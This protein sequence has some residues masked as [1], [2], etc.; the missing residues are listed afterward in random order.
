MTLLEL[1]LVD[2]VPPPSAAAVGSK[3]HVPCPPNITPEWAKTL[4]PDLKGCWLVH[5][6]VRHMRWQS[7][8][9]RK[10][11]P[12]TAS[13]AYGDESEI[14]EWDSLKHALQ[15]VWDCHFDETGIVCPYIFD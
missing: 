5:D 14:S 12:R 4:K 15:F 8:Y 1:L 11:V 6:S 3:A 9:P 7:G 2:D 10:T 13:I